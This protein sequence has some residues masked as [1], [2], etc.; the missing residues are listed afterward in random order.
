MRPNHLAADGFVAAVDDPVW[1]Q[2]TPP[3][4][5]NCRCALAIVTKRKAR[6]AGVIDEDGSAIF[7]AKPAGAGPD[8]GFRA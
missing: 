8:A 4:G 5:F 2:L 3:L 6:Q 7:Q 1:Q